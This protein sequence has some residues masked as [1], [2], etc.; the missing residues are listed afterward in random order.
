M[1]VSLVSTMMGSLDERFVIIIA[2]T[3]FF[4]TTIGVYLIYKVAPVEQMTYETSQ[5]MTRNRMMAR[6]LAL[7]L[8]PVG[9]A[10]ALLIAPQLGIL[11][12]G[13]VAFLV[14]GASLIPA[15]IYAWKDDASVRTLDEEVPTFIRSLGNVAGATGVT[16]TE[17]LK[18]I[19]MKSMGS[20]QPHIER[21]DIRLGARLPT[22]ECWEAFRR[23]SGSELVNRSTQMLVDG[24]ELGGRTDQVGET[25]SNYAANIIHLRSKRALTATTFAFLTVPMHATMAFILIFVLEIVSN[26]N[27]MIS[28]SSE[29]LGGDDKAIALPETLQLPPGMYIPGQ[30]ELAGGLDLFGAQDMTLIS[31]VI[32]LVVGIL[33]FANALAP[34]FAGGGSNLMILSFLSIMCIISGAVLGIVPLVTAKIF[35]A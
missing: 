16:L 10:L 35:G 28:G 8:A 27:S 34:K 9:V 33:T 14:I 21:L 15:G 18:R 22:K 3:L 32:L 24:S 26:F 13:S 17:A 5:G 2:C 4:I 31:T 19:D 20:L 7:G 6:R 30:V 23:E 25:C 11:T 12:G 29:L 1:V